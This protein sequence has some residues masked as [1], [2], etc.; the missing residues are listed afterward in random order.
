[1]GDCTSPNAFD[2][3]VLDWVKCEGG[4]HGGVVWDP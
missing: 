3:G 1:M 4:G 2:N